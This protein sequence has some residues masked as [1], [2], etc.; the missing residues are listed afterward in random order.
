MARPSPLSRPGPQLAQRLGP[1][2]TGGDVPYDP[3]G[4]DLD[5]EN[6]QDAI[7]ELYDLIASGDLGG[8]LPLTAVVD[9][10]P[11]LVWDEDNSLIPVDF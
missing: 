3:D 2:L 1:P 9:G 7:D 10:E 5:A 4:T 11:V 6:V 8:V